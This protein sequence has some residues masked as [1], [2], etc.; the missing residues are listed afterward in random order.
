MVSIFSGGHILKIQP[1][2]PSEHALFYQV[3]LLEGQ[4]KVNAA[5][6]LLK[7]I[8]LPLEG[9]RLRFIVDGNYAAL[10]SRSQTELGS[11][12]VALHIFDWTMEHPS[13]FVYCP[14]VRLFSLLSPLFSN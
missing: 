13:L 10:Q 5:F 12:M 6:E 8:K 4:G 2:F 11:D 1:H 9:L 3:R 14:P 7:E